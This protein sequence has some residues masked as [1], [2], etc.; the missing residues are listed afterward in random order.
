MGPKRRAPPP[1]TILVIHEDDIDEYV[2]ILP[3]TA[4]FRRDNPN[5]HRVD[6][7]IDSVIVG[8]AAWRLAAA[9]SDHGRLQMGPGMALT[10][11]NDNDRYIDVSEQ[12]LGV[13]KPSLSTTYSIVSADDRHSGMGD[14]LSEIDGEPNDRKHTK[15]SQE[16]RDLRLKIKRITLDEDNFR[17]FGLTRAFGR[18]QSDTVHGPSA[19]F[20][21]YHVLK[22]GQNLYL[23]T[24]PDLQHLWCLNGP[25]YFVE[26]KRQEGNCK[27]SFYS[28]ESIESPAGIIL[29]KAGSDW[30]INGQL[31]LRK[32]FDLDESAGIK[33][34]NY[35][36]SY[37]GVNW[38]I[39]FMPQPKQRKFSRLRK[40]GASSGQEP[41]KKYVGK[42]NVYFYNKEDISEDMETSPLRSICGAFRPQ[43][44]KLR[45]KIIREVKHFYQNDPS[46]SSF[47]APAK[48]ISDLRAGTSVK[49]FL[50][51]SDGL[52]AGVPKDDKPNEDKLGWLTIYQNAYIRDNDTDSELFLVL[53][54]S[55]LVIGLEENY[56]KARLTAS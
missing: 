38:T 53:L 42:Q 51:A 37:E 44:V 8:N 20:W 47:E 7:D 41:V 35:A 25:G 39:G 45:K 14:E 21:K 18:L 23:T 43:E 56:S 54:A 31:L 1:E 17:G 22:F 46:S 11:L 15:I 24:N 32:T 52:Q 34:A 28:L 6:S 16:Y 4:Q 19:L 9:M 29:E 48:E 3:L 26:I 12:A 55:T 49:K 5:L 33:S 27:Y 10:S 50:A 2:R 36:L 40:L 13:S 30:C